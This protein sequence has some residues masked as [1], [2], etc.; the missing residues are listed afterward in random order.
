M[1][2]V[3]HCSPCLSNVKPLF[4]A[5]QTL[6]IF[7]LSRSCCSVEC[8]IQADIA[9]QSIRWLL[10]GQELVHSDRV[11]MSYIEDIGLA[12]LTVHQVGP[13]DSG[14]YACVV[15]GSV[16]EPQTGAQIPKTISSS[17]QVTI[18]GKSSLLSN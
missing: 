15:V 16:T 18:E 9:P 6:V 14:E 1:A 10:N 4:P 13:R 17:S 5:V 7:S 8:Q 2:F 11:E 3:Q 12:Q